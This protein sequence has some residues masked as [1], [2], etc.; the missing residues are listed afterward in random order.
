MALN[1]R[2]GTSVRC[3]L[4]GKAL[5]EHDVVT[6]RTGLVA[7]MNG[8]GRTVLASEGDPEG[9]FL[10]QSWLLLH[11]A[12]AVQ[13]LLLM[14]LVGLLL[15][16]TCIGLSLVSRLLPPG[17]HTNMP[18]SLVLKLLGL[19]GWL[20]GLQLL[21]GT[22]TGSGFVIG[23]ALLLSVLVMLVCSSFGGYSVWFR[24]FQLAVA[25]WGQLAKAGGG[26][27]FIN[28]RCGWQQ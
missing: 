21:L 14:L 25:M 18:L 26:H 16:T 10:S 11:W 8:M 17:S 4:V 3:M 1:N 27:K 19:Q 9:M 28:L 12:S 23:A 24:W 2:T 20:L 7:S 13:G 6:S 15:L 22:C 5:V